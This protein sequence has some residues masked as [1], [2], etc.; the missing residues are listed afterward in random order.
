MWYHWHAE[1]FKNDTNELL[2]TKQKH[3]LKRTSLWLPGGK[4]V[5]D[6]LEVWNG[7]VYTGI[8]KIDK[9]RG[10]TV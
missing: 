2:F 3:R 9:E 7:R 4:R 10:P 5:S 8:F 1:S 6:R